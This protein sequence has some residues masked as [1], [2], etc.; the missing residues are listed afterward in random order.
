MGSGSEDSE[1]ERMITRARKELHCMTAGGSKIET[2]KDE[3]EY[4]FLH[5]V[6]GK[7]GRETRPKGI[8]LI[9]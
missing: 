2:L 4:E 6:A 8:T 5:L 7:G 9:E 3:S 1:S